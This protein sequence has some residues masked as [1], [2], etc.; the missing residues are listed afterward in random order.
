MD[1]SLAWLITLRISWKKFRHNFFKF[2]TDLFRLC[3][4]SKFNLFTKRHLSAWRPTS[5]WVNNMNLGRD[6]F[7]KIFSIYFRKYL[8][9]PMGCIFVETEAFR[10]KLNALCWFF[11]RL[12][13]HFYHYFFQILK[14]S[15][16]YHFIFSWKFAQNKFPKCFC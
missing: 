3:K 6:W 7:W 1:L 13:V 4:R 15:G 8:V 11:I 9:E 2:L 14:F 5:K 16:F 10:R 12:D